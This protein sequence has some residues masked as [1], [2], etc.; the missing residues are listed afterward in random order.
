VISASPPYPDELL[1]CAVTRCC[2]WHCVP[3]KRLAALCLGNAQVRPNLLAV[4]PV[5]LF[6]RLFEVT[7]EHLLWNHTTFPYATACCSTAVYNAALAAAFAWGAPYASLLAVMQNASFGVARRRLCPEC[8]AAELSNFGTSYWHRCHH[9]PGVLLCPE[10][11]RPLTETDLP[12]T[13]VLATIY[14]LPHEATRVRDVIRR[15]TQALVKITKCSVALLTRPSG[16]GTALGASVYRSLAIAEG[17]LSEGRQ[18]SEL[19]LSNALRRTFLA[20]QLE[21][22]GVPVASSTGWPSLL[23]REG[24]SFNSPPLRH[25]VLRTTL[26]LAPHKPRELDHVSTGPSGTS[27]SAEDAFYAP[28]AREV[29]ARA[30]QQGDV[31]TT[32]QFLRRSASFGAYRHLGT[33]LPQLRE[34]V[35]AFRSTPASVKPLRAD[36]SLYRGSSAATEA[37]RKAFSDSEAQK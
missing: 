25:L 35:R 13:N 30:L 15:P 17:W 9:L 36:A 23:F 24:T 37:G 3:M 34:V 12:A 16:P 22:M 21:A 2:R 33:H 18:V 7:P 6:T 8:V 11:G 14:T 20:S 31:L 5:S 28:R 27:S 26:E 29:L 1:P 19:A 32:E 4:R 10:H